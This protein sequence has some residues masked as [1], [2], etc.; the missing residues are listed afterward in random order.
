MGV[1]WSLF[2]L[3]AFFFPYM[4]QQQVSAPAFLLAVAAFGTFLALVYEK[5][6]GHVLASMLAHFSLNAALAMGGARFS[7][8]LWWFLAASFVLLGAWSLAALRGSPSR[9]AETIQS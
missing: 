1:L 3:P 7:S 5:T 4:P 8:T 9:A 2:H 6:N